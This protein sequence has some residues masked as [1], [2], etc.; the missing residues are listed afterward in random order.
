MKTPLF[1]PLTF[2]NLTSDFILVLVLVSISAYLCIGQRSWE[3]PEISDLTGTGAMC[4]EPLSSKKANKARRH[5]ADGAPLNIVRRNGR[6]HYVVGGRRKEVERAVRAAQAERNQAYGEDEQEEEEEE[7]KEEDDDD[8]GEENDHAGHGPG[9]DIHNGGGAY[10]RGGGSSERPWPSAKSYAQTS[11]AALPKGVKRESGRN[12]KHSQQVQGSF[13]E[14][15]PTFGRPSDTSVV[16]GS[17]T[18][19]SNFGGSYGNIGP[20][21]QNVLYKDAM[22]MSA[23]QRNH[24]VGGDARIPDRFMHGFESPGNGMYGHA[25]PGMGDYGDY[26]FKSYRNMELASAR[27]EMAYP[28]GNLWY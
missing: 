27:R 11:K 13:E 21:R 1:T 24:G 10:L 16:Y 7:E 17:A 5:Y 4:W 3:T 8:A 15:F 12:T 19:G 22:E 26:L 23:F 25:V 28:E 6:L 2:L 18:R 9:N 20:G 14:T